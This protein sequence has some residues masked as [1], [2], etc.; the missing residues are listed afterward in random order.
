MLISSEQ[1]HEDACRS[2]NV[3]RRAEAPAAEAGA[4]GDAE[5]ETATAESGAAGAAEKAAIAG[6]DPG[7]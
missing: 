6:I 1:V 7:R 5:E 2:S 4:V 3:A